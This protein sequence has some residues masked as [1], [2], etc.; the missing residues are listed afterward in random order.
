MSGGQASKCRTGSRANLVAATPCQ[1]PSN[2]L[3]R[4]AHH[5]DEL[6]HRIALTSLKVR[7]EYAVFA[8]RPSVV[9]NVVSIGGGDEAVSAIL[10]LRAASPGHS[11][12]DRPFPIVRV[13]DGA[14]GRIVSK[15]WRLHVTG[16]GSVAIFALDCLLS[17]V[18]IVNHNP[19]AAR[20]LVDLEVETRE[21]YSLR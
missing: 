13:D 21:G 19:R 9:L 16:V 1:Q 4:V 18:D 7:F 14:S 3:I 20:F 11:S 15:A 17:A 10:H 6:P 2:S 12:A 5:A 8:D